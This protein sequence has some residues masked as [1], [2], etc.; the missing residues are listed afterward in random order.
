MKIIYI[1]KR[2][3]IFL[4]VLFC[5]TLP[6]DL[7]GCVN[8]LSASSQLSPQTPF[9]ILCI[10]PD[11]IDRIYLMNEDASNNYFIKDPEKVKALVNYCKTLELV[12]SGLHTAGGFSYSFTFYSGNV[13]LGYIVPYGTLL[14]INRSDYTQVGNETNI[15]IDFSPYFKIYQNPIEIMSFPASD[16]K[17]VGIVDGDTRKEQY[18]DNLKQIENMRVCLWAAI[19]QEDT[20]ETEISGLSDVLNFYSSDDTLLG[21]FSYSGTQIFIKGKLYERVGDDA[22]VPFDFEQ[23]FT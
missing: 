20:G 4:V 8:H 3:K 21:T 2:I 5:F 11:K 1:I 15:P 14:G 23:F 16:V 22:D 10:D 13:D 6:A 12:Y 17:K 19:I 7:S 9:E 18:L